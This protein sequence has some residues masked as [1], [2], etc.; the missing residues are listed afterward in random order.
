M[1][2]HLR[3]H[4]NITANT[5]LADDANML[6]PDMDRRYLTIVKLDYDRNADVTVATLRPVMP[7]EFRERVMRLAETQAKPAARLRKLFNG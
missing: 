7:A 2:E 6:G 5:E 3:Y 1:S 4:G